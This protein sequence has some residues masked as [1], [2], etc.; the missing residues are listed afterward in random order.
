MSAIYRFYLIFSFIIVSININAQQLSQSSVDK[1]W[2]EIIAAIGNNNPREPKLEFKNSKRN[3]ASYS[4]KK[5]TIKIENKVLEICYS[6][7]K[8]SLNAFSYI[9]AHELAHHYKDHGWTTQYASL[10]F[11]NEIDEKQESAQQ[12]VDDETQADIY[13]GFY[14]HIAGYDALKVAD[15][16]LDAIYKSYALPHELKNYPTLEERKA[17]IEQN[18]SDFEELRDIFDLANIVM[19]LGKYNYAQELYDYIINKG[20]TSREIYNNLGLCYVYEALALD[21]EDAYFNLLIPFTVDLSTR[22]ESNGSTRGAM[23]AKQQAIILFNNAKREFETAIQ[24][25]NNYSIGKENLFFTDVALTYLG[26]TVKNQITLDD[27]IAENQCCEFCVRGHSAVVDQKLSK[28][29]K[30]FKKGSAKCPIC[31]I[32]TDFRKKQT[33]KTKKHLKTQW[34]IEDVNGIDMICTYF[35]PGDCD[36]FYR[37]NASKICIKDHSGAKVFMLKKIKSSCVSIQEISTNNNRFKNNANIYI[38]DNIDKIHN[39]QNLRIVNAANNKYISIVDEQLT[40]LVENGKIEKWYYFE[41]I[42]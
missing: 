37:L 18:R 10:D 13:A 1:V 25:D 24:L 9:L 19:S 6:F 17:I 2:N 27:L 40:F 33:P 22:L 11:S 35:K 4:P 15:S 8:D 31:E 34:D 5:K 21:I 3:P 14:A 39:Y 7:G 12:R 16:F 41:Q 42:E 26:E 23:T 28:A 29:N 32:N 30:L 38:G 36:K 20:F